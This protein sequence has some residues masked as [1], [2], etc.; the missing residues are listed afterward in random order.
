MSSLDKTPCSC[1]DHLSQEAI[2]KRIIQIQSCLIQEQDFQAVM[3]DQAQFLEQATKA[4]MMAIC[5]NGRQQFTL[6][7]SVTAKPQILASLKKYKIK[8]QTLTVDKFLTHYPSE[9][10]NNEKKLGIHSLDSVFDGVLTKKQSQC[11]EKDIGFNSAVF[12]SLFSSEGDLIGYIVYFYL[13]NPQLEE[14]YLKRVTALIQ[15]IVQPLYDWSTQT[16][17]SQCS[18]MTHDL[19]NLTATE[20]RIL[21]QLMDAKPSKQIAH[22]SH[23]SMNT[24]K[25]H[26][27]NIYAKLEVN[28]KME[29]SNKLKRV[30]F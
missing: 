30:I 18:R 9:L 4:S 10:L 14:R 26:I 13:D 29:L 12:H 24:V 17:Y 2:Y 20:K 8:P 5:L 11:F 6:E 28:S 15:T 23:I 22:D 3:N 25:S 1:P 21:H 27:K 7:L 16:F 19:L